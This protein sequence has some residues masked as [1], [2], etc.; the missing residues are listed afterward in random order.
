MKF[1]IQTKLLVYILSTSSLI[2]LLAFGYL[3]YTDYKASTAE[4]KKLTDTYAEKYANTIMNELNSDLTVARTLVQSFSQ[5][6]K[7]YYSNKQ[8]IYYDM[9]LNILENNPQFHNVALNF[10]LSEVDK[11]YHKNYGRIRFILYKSSGLI[12]QMIDTLE[13]AGDNVGGPYYDMKINPREEY[14]EPYM[15][16]PTGSNNDLTLVSSLSMPIMDEKRYVGLLQFDV[17]LERFRTMINEI[18]PYPGSYGFLLSNKGVYIATPD[19]DIVNKSIDKTIPEENLEQNILVNIKAGK[20]FSYLKKDSSDYTDYVSY[21]PLKFGNAPAYWSLGITVPYKVMIQKAKRNLYFSILVAIVGFIILTLVIWLIA[22]GISKPLSKTADIIQNLARGNI[23]SELKLHISGRDEITDIGNSVNTLID[24]LENNL[25]FALQIG[26]GNLDY[27]FELTSNKDVLGKAL[28]DMRKSLKQAAAEEENRKSIDMKLNWATKGFAQF[29]EL[30]RE[31]TDK[32]SEFSYN[33]I[34][35]LVRYLNASQGGLFIINDTRKDDVFIELSASYAYD[36]RK[37]LEKKIK[38]GVG[39]VGRCI[40]ERETIFMTDFPADYLNISSGLGQAAPRCLLLVPVVFNQQVF[41]VI[42]MASFKI[43]EKYQIE[44]VERI[45]E[46]IGSTISNVKINEQTAKL[47]E[48]SKIQREELVAQE[49]EM[50]QNLEEMK[51]TQEELERKAMDFEGIIKALNSVALVAEFD[52]QGRLIEIN[53]EFLRLLNKSKDEM[54]GTFQGAFA[55]TKEDR[56]N[57]FRDFWND[58][59]RGM[60]K[61]TIQ[62]INVNDRD[63]WLSETYTPIYDKDGNPY[64][65][66]NI[67]I[68]ITESMQEKAIANE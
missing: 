43:M 22:R 9:L 23:S 39:L 31:N 17:N 66:L 65:V 38:M 63:I 10:E 14:S 53:R 29:G 62:H 21:F 24:G 8:G 35:N 34:S 28:L 4:A 59:R 58:L 6:K 47:L 7:F 51:A 49:E 11:N 55:I 30:M 25:K 60:L 64:K 33:I 56:R 19:D 26:R 67:S 46:S 15:F 20:H 12:Q 50:R 44:F 57:I 16:S 52:M 61:K 13:L 48:E 68:D 54:I 3:S 36:R 2:Y 27:N 45:G 5:Y 41:G 32:L 18:R 37:Y 40:N 42:E 1:R